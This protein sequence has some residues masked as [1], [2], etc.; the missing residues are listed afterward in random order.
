MNKGKKAA[1]RRRPD[2]IAKAQPMKMVIPMKDGL[3]P[4][5]VT[6]RFRNHVYDEFASRYLEAIHVEPT[7][8]NITRMRGVVPPS[9]ISLMPKFKV[10]GCIRDEVSIDRVCTQTRLPGFTNNTGDADLFRKVVNT[11]SCSME[12]I[13]VPK[14]PV[15]MQCT[16]PD[17][18]P[19]LQSD[20][21]NKCDIR[22]AWY[23]SKQQ[24]QRA[25]ADFSTQHPLT[26]IQR[27]LKEDQLHQ[28][29]KMLQ[30][31]QMTDLVQT[32]CH[33]LH[34]Q[35]F[36]MPNIRDPQALSQTGDLYLKPPL[37][38]RT[39][40]ATVWR[41]NE[42]F[43]LLL[44][45]YKRAKPLLT[46]VAVMVCFTARE[47]SKRLLTV[48][49][50]QWCRTIDGTTFL[51]KVDDLA[52]EKLDPQSYMRTID[53]FG[54]GR[55]CTEHREAIGMDQASRALPRRKWMRQ[56]YKLSPLMSTLAGSLMS[57]EAK[58][59]INPHDRARGGDAGNAMD[60][61]SRTKR[62]ESMAMGMRKSLPYAHTNI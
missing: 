60:D 7:K 43:A 30:S 22:E 29:E 46:V 15:Q 9:S 58:R 33:F 61:Y 62:V 24:I 11:T 51:S 26:D 19:V 47:V 4:R 40:E 6:P 18:E 16:A 1:G 55:T 49:F 10:N 54:D 41:M 52:M 28:L 56:M 59:A 25:L 35:I 42:A 31:E 38:Q 57:N 36:V 50:P 27:S 20:L 5:D 37:S 32:M 34:N 2:N 14:V 23:P 21:Q 8:A 39:F 3:Q 13:K 17:T 12:N 45:P 53:L 44:A 48:E